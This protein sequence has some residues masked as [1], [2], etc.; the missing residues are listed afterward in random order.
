MLDAIIEVWGSRA[1][2]I[3]I[4]P[5]DDYNDTAVSYGELT[6]T[7]TYFIKELMRRDLAFVNLSRRGCDLERETDEYF[8]SQPRA[9]GKELPPAYDP[10]VQFGHL[11]KYPGSRTLLMVNHEYTVEEG[12]KLIKQEKI[13]LVTFGRPFIYNPVTSKPVRCK[14]VSQML[15]QCFLGF[16]QPRQG[17]CTFRL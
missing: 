9:H 11:I 6:N 14:V 5:T 8:R 10:L 1:V 15:T 17:R 4:C 2:G 12:S 7:Y 16:G 13:D 3:K